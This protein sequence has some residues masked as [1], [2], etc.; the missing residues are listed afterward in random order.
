MGTATAHRHTK[1]LGAANSDVG[2]KLANRCKQHLG[3]G[4]YSHRDK[5]SAVVG[6]GDAGGRIPKPPTTTWKLEQNPKDIVTPAECFGLHHLKL[7]PNG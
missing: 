4:V 7:H 2:T 1:T 3:K 6:S 5:S